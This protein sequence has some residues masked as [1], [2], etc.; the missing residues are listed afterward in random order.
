MA[1]PS[2]V[3]NGRQTS[4]LLAAATIRCGKPK[5]DRDSI[6]T[7]KQNNGW[8]KGNYKLEGGEPASTEQ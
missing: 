3:R 7:K 4:S 5:K 2:P 6:P 1:L 8:T